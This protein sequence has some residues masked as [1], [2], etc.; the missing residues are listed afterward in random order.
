MMWLDTHFEQLEEKY[1]ASIRA[2]IALDN[3]WYFM[4][5]RPDFAEALM[6]LTPRD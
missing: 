5:T 2:A 6:L 4:W 1:I 3:F